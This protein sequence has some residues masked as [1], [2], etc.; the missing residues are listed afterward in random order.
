MQHLGGELQRRGISRHSQWGAQGI[1]NY[2]NSVII[3][4]PNSKRKTAFTADAAVQTS[5]ALEDGGGLRYSRGSDSR[6]ENDS[7]L[8]ANDLDSILKWSSEISSNMNLFSSV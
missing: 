1:V 2:L 5:N 7:N 3:G 4:R 8:S 6:S